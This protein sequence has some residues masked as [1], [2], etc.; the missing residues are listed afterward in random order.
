MKKIVIIGAGG[1]GA[2]AIWALEEMNKLSPLSDHWNILGYVDDNKSK[3]GKVFYNYPTL[4]T[5]GEVDKIYSGNQLWY[6]C[7]IGDNSARSNMVKS[8][9]ELA[10][11]AA[12]L[13]HPSASLAKNIEIGEGSYIGPASVICPN[14]IIRKHVLINT[15]VAIGHDVIMEDFSQACPGAQINGFCKIG[16]SSFIGSN[17]SVMPGTKIGEKATV[18]ANSQVLRAVKSGTTVNGVP[19]LKVG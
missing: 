17:A 1:F 16:Q 7:A 6:F 19:A 12:T 5:P 13:I 4:G 18:G 3:K 14:A 2:E 10:W 9:D 8:L 15:R 11:K